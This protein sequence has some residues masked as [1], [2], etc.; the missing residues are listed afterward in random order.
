[1]AKHKGVEYDRIQLGKLLLNILVE[2]KEGLPCAD[3]GMDEGVEATLME[4][5]RRLSRMLIKAFSDVH[6]FA[7]ISAPR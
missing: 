7:L 1:M 5:S 2:V 6:I 3:L 4:R